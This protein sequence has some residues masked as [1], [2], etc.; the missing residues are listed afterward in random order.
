M[1]NS[2]FKIDFFLIPL[3]G[4]KGFKGLSGLSG[5]SRPNNPFTNPSVALRQ[6]LLGGATERNFD[7]PSR[8]P[9]S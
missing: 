5:P 1:Q 7:H 8:P 9:L 3:K 4:F 6:L 2:K